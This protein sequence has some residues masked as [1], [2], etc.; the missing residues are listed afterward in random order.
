MGLMQ[1]L[2]FLTIVLFYV[3]YFSKLLLQRRQGISTDRMGRG[4]KPKRTRIIENLL[5]AATY[6]MAAV[7]LISLFAGTNGYDLIPFDAV[8]Y[9]G[10]GIALVGTGVFITAMATMKN[11]W[12]AGVDASQHTELI[13]RGIYRFSRNPAFL[14]FDLFY[15]GF[16]LAFCNPVILVFLIFCVVLLHLQILEEEKYLP[17]AFGKKYADYRKSVARY[18]IFF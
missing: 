11:S 15:I 10:L 13:R 16:V 2:G 3:S 17:L 7:Q 18:F 1:G 12:R 8:R 6:S 14:G 4:D 9:I 5:R